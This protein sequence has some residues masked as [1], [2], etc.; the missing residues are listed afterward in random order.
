[1]SFKAIRKRLRPV[2][3]IVETARIRLVELPYLLRRPPLGT[4]D[5]LIQ[6]E[7]CYGGFV[8]NVPRRR[9]SS[10][11]GRTP[12]QLAFGGMTGGDRMLHHGYGVTYSRFLAPF[13]GRA[14][15]T[16]AEFGILKGAGLAIWCDLFADAR[17][18]GFDIDLSHFEENRA[19]LIQ[20]HAFQRTTPEVHE[21]DQLVDGGAA[22]GNILK[23]A[24]LDVVIDDGLH[25]L[26]AIVMT[27]RSVR[28]HLADRFV[29]FIEDYG[30]LPQH[31]GSEFDEFKVTANGL[32]TVV[33]R[34]VAVGDS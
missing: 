9:V 5:W 3:R 17:V 33:S 22:L 13:I 20:R 34:G 6:R 24:R 7:A 27:W 8:T 32:M 14:G 30:N 4:R 21:Y 26:A 25:S 16:V 31:V 23:G 29:Y 12:D 15:L 10:L 11:D 2:R 1:M 19:R 18:L 28:P